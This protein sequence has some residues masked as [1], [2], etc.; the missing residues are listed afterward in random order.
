MAA[1]LSSVRKYDSSSLQL[2]AAKLGEVVV[3]YVTLLGVAFSRLILRNKHK[4]NWSHMIWP[5]FHLY[6]H[7]FSVPSLS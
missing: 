6:V 1:L 3:V 2:G 7:R 5:A 4:I